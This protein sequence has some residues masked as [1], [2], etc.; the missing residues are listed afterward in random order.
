MAKVKHGLH[1]QPVRPPEGARRAIYVGSR[2]P[3]NKGAGVLLLRE[4]VSSSYILLREVIPGPS[5]AQGALYP[6][7]L[8]SKRSLF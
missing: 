7:I 1:V 6:E 2:C 4:P 8:R 5:R 3:L